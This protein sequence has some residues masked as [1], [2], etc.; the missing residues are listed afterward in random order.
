MRRPPRTSGQHLVRSGEI[1]HAAREP[2]DSSFARPGPLPGPWCGGYPPGMERSP[3]AQAR[4]RSRDVPGTTAPTAGVTPK[5]PASTSTPRPDVIRVVDAS[6]PDDVLVKGLRCGDAGAFETVLSRYHHA[7][8]RVALLY[9]RE[10]ETAEEVAQETWLAVIEGLDRF[11]ERSSFRTWVFRIL[12]NIARKR[13]P[14]ERRSVPFSQLAARE[15]GSREPLVDPGRF[16]GPD[17]PEW[18]GHWISAVPNWGERADSAL[19]EAETLKYIATQ[20]DRL[21]PLQREVMRLRDIDGWSPEEV[22]AVLRIT[23]VNQRVLLHRARTAIRNALE[24]YFGE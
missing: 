8:I 22:S 7:M 23:R 18:E 16:V 10:P 17:D 9:V 11:E 14:R 15:L 21:P 4:T 5:A 3:T 12:T 1:T 24:A 6:T 13:G 2:P 19:L 20:M